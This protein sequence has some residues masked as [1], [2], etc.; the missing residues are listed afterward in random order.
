[1][2]IR[3]ANN[4]IRKVHKDEVLEKSIITS[5]YRE[6]FEGFHY[7]NDAIS[8]VSFFNKSIKN[9]VIEDSFPYYYEKRGLNTYF[10]VQFRNFCSST[11]FELYPEFED[12][13]K[14]V[15][16]FLEEKDNITFFED[17][18]KHFKLQEDL[19]K[20][21]FSFDIGNKIN[22]INYKINTDNLSIN[23][24]FYICLDKIMV[25]LTCYKIKE[26]HRRTIKSSY[27]F[28]HKNFEE[29]LKYILSKHNLFLNFKEEFSSIYVNLAEAE[30]I[31]SMIEY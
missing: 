16:R 13:I 17:L 4:I 29:I 24:D 26:N 15:K 5:S 28:E 20:I 25:D 2:H 7:F 22:S 19:P 3:T 1:M 27:D 23:F 21:E 10:E 14:F 12:K 8:V 30:K 11:S 31:S 9:F 6:P 18:I